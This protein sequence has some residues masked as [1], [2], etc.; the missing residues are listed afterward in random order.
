MNKPDFIQGILLAAGQG[1]RFGGDKLLHR[2]PGGEV[3]ALASARH[4]A[5]A[6]PA[7]L[8]VV[9]PEHS[10]LRALLEEAGIPVI[11]APDAERG[12][13]HSLAAGVAA[14]AQAS[15]WVIALADMPY[16]QRSTIAAIADGLLA[17]HEIVAPA[18]HG[19][20]GNPVGISAK[21]REALL[22]LEGDAGAR[23]LLQARRELVHL[24]EVG[25]PGVIHDIDTPQDL[26]RQGSAA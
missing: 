23:H 15:G 2:L 17:G 10:A 7:V 5:S 4:L 19:R 24:I 20:R 12:M 18:Y 3:M 1:S 16:V 8:A 6:L 14:S 9:R 21:H 13:G 26:A 22:A 25:D 11:I